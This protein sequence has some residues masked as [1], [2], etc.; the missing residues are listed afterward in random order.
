MSRKAGVLLAAIWLMIGVED[1]NARGVIFWGS[2]EVIHEIQSLPGGGKVGY[3]QEELTVFWLPLMRGNGKFVV[4]RGDRYQVLPTE[5]LDEFAA[6]A[7][8]PEGSIRKPLLAYVPWPYLVALV[9]LVLAV[10]KSKRDF[11]KFM[12]EQ[13]MRR[14][15]DRSE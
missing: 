15:R 5:Q 12:E 10:I 6:A 1:A 3:F 8:L 4:Y 9:L 2:G 14:Q 13:E 7:G 11:R